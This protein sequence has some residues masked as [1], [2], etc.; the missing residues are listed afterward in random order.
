MME[1]FLQVPLERTP[2]SNLCSFIMLSSGLS[3]DFSSETMAETMAWSAQKKSPHC[4]ISW[5]ASP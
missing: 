1:Q 3:C 5:K 2:N 4:L